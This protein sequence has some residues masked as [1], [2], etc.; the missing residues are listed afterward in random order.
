MSP[1]RN[2]PPHR[3]ARYWR[4][5]RPRSRLWLAIFGWTLWGLIGLVV[6][7]AVGGYIALD[8]TLEAAAP[9]TPEARAARAA[10]RPA[11]PGEP[12]NILLIGSDVRADEGG[13]GRSDT[14]ILVRMDSRRG[15][16]SMLSFPRDLY[17]P[18]DG[19]L[20][21]K[22]NAAYSRGTDV[23][24]RTVEQLTGEPVN[25]YVDINFT[26]FAELVNELG[27]VYIDVDRRYYNPEGTGYAPIDLQPGYQRLNGN[28]ALDYVR[29]R[30]TDSTY[31]RDARQQMFLAELKRQTKDIGSIASLPRLKRL[32]GKD[33]QMDITN[34]RT[35]LSLL[36]LALVT[37]K[38]KIAKVKIQGTDDMTSAGASIQTASEATIDAAVAE[39][40]D[41]SFEND[42]SPGA[43]AR[44]PSEVDVTVLNGSGRVLAAEDVAE[45]LSD[46]GYRARVGGNA[47]SFDF[48]SSAVYYAPA[49]RD[50]AKKIQALLGP[51]ASSAPLA[52]RQARGN[53][54]VVVAGTDFTGTLAIPPKAAER[55]AASTIDTTSLVDGVRRAQRALGFRMMV[56]MKVA[57]GSRLRILRAYRI[58]V[59][60]G[61]GG[62][63][64]VKMVFETGY[65]KYW[66]I[67]MT[68]MKNPP[69]VGGETGS[70]DSGGRKYLTYYDG[71]N[72]QRLAFRK[73]NVTFW[74]S[75]TLE[76][77]LSAKTIEE[78][79]KSM[80]PVNR[81]KLPKGRTD[82]PI[83]VEF[84]GSTP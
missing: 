59:G 5:P 84:E 79:A 42:T 66:G 51:S 49:Y 13:P 41:P 35:F 14:L 4:V 43:R 80:R 27:G 62:P 7:V 6:A 2:E 18:I 52:A 58:N 39:W 46:K 8:D 40:K 24:I 1:P 50:A 30:H 69:I 63:A 17:V 56:P 29:Y 3:K 73:G 53:E 9:N 71:L 21:D 28:D 44:K 38:D 45:A 11:L 23:A 37:P 77:D 67:T 70:Y 36:E 82:T 34:P 22:I 83:Y 26:G 47:E 68:T 65:H 60:S 31:A 10:T 76:N 33:I 55:P 15:F 72:L 48:T 81:A 25:Y 16:I 20:P 12:K 75:N 19:G 32:F 74:V 61:D 78:I 57:S 54:V 64:A